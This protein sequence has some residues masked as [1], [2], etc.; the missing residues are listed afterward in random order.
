MKQPAKRPL[1]FALAILAG[2]TIHES[3]Q[4]QA[5]GTI[6]RY[7]ADGRVIGQTKNTILS[8]PA[9]P[10]AP[11]G[12]AGADDP[13]ATAA[14]PPTGQDIPAYTYES[15]QVLAAS[16]DSNFLRSARSLGFSVMERVELSS[17]DLSVVKLRTP[18]AADTRDALAL[19]RAAFPQIASDLNNQIIP[20]AHNRGWD[21]AGTVGWP[22]VNAACGR[23]VT[24]GMIDTPVDV[25]HEAFT[26]RQIVHRSFLAEDLVPATATHGTAIAALLIG[27]PESDG[28]GGLLPGATLI[29]ASIFERQVTGRTVGNLFGLLKAL[30]WMAAE[31]VDVLNLSLETGENLILSKAVERTL[32]SGVVIIAAAGNGGAMAGPAYPAALPS[33]IAVTAL[34][35]G[36]EP[37]AFANHGDY[38]D[39]AAPGVQLWTAVPGGG[40][41]Q[42]GTSFAVPFLTAATAMQISNG[43]AANAESIRTALV[44]YTRD[45]GSPGKDEIFGWGLVRFSPECG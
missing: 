1:I 23:G 30:D 42:S 6:L 18:A 10:S 15:N 13:S 17:L 35:P 16:T 7:D 11:A 4:G 25:T 41:V 14:Q 9:A 8:A 19:L 21:A 40:Q 32:Q 34:D 24:I 20:A 29:A 33:V 2:L 12:P 43:T 28:Y 36:F 27:D 45:L 26:G 38:I 37:Y 5:T 3:S 22:E 31:Q 44:E 39:F